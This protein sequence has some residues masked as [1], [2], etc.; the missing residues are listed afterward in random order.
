L[1]SFFFCLLWFINSQCPSW[2]IDL[3]SITL[4]PY[5]AH[6]L[7]HGAVDAGKTPVSAFRLP[8]ELFD[9]CDDPITGGRTTL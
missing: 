5:R 8:H 6:G 3:S 1:R 9:R 4:S 2:G 7:R